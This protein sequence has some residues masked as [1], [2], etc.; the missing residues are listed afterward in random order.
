MM[1]MAMLVTVKA[2][3]YIF[4]NVVHS[5]QNR[6]I[7][8]KNLI[9]ELSLCFSRVPKNVHLSQKWTVC[10]VAKLKIKQSLCLVF[11]IILLRSCH[12]KVFLCY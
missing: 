7:L 6:A 9:I 10:F 1:D 12:L 11:F 8:S 2:T 4:S 5:C 3:Q